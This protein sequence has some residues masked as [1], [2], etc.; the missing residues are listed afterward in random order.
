MLTRMQSFFSGTSPPL[1]LA[2]LGFVIAGLGVAIA[3]SIDY[4]PHNA[5]SFWVFGLVAFGVGLGFC[6]IAWGWIQAI[7]KLVRRVRGR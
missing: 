2:F 1:R 7:A 5:L 4:G 3:F 6:A